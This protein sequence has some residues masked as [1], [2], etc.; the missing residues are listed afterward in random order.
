MVAEVSAIWA[1]R[2]ARADSAGVKGSPGRTKTYNPLHGEGI[3]KQV[4][5]VGNRPSSSFGSVTSRAPS[6]SATA[7]DSS[8]GSATT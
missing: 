6:N 3:F 7:C 1:R 4:P 2:W 5:S 8:A